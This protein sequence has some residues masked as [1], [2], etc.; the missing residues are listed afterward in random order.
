MTFPELIFFEVGEN[1]QFPFNKN[2]GEISSGEAKLLPK[3]R[4][5]GTCYKSADSI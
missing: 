5:R 2:E 1:K 3:L 4:R